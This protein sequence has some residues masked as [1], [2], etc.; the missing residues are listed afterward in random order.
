MPWLQFLN[1][2][3]QR[4]LAADIA[5]AQVLRQSLRLT[6]GRDRAVLQN[7]FDLGPKNKKLAVPEI[8]KWFFPETVARTEQPPARAVPDGE[9]KHAAKPRQASGPELLVRM[10][11]RLGVA[12]GGVAV[13]RLLQFG[14]QFRVIENFAVVDDL[15]R[16]GFVCHRLVAGRKVDD[17]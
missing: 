16:A 14:P 2:A 8:V 11:N 10:N 4:L 3:K 7:D 6:L 17:A 15:K 13:A 12:V 5:E 1:A 9:R